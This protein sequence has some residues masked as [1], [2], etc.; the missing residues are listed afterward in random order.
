[1]RGLGKPR[2]ASQG[3]PRGTL[4]RVLLVEDSEN[5]AILLLRELRRGGYEPLCERVSTPEEMERALREAEERGE[6]WEV[7]VSDY[8]LPR[9][10]A[11]DALALLRRLGYVT[12]FILVSSKVGE[13]AAVAMMRAGAQDYVSKENLARL[14]PAIER[15]LREAADRRERAKAEEALR[16]SEDRFRRL[17]E[18]AADA[19]LVYDLEGNFVDVN[20]RACE[21]LGY[22]REE[23][24]GMSMG[25]VEAGEASGELGRLWEETSA[26]GPRT[27][28]TLHRRKDGTTFPV[29]VRVGVFELGGRPLVLALARDVT[30][31]KE[32]EKR[33]WEAETR[34]RTLVERIPAITYIQSPEGKKQMEYV[35]PQLEDVL[36]YS[37]E[38]E[39]IDDEFLLRTVHPE[40][41]DRFASEDRR[42]D[43]TGEPFRVE[44]RQLAS[45]G[46]EVW[47]R[48]EAVLVRDDEGRP[49]YWL[50]VQY[51]ITDRKRI[52]EDSRASEERY[53]AFIE[54][55]T[56]GIWRFEFEEEIPTDL[57][58]DEQISRIYR[59]GY[60]AECNDAMARMYGYER[61]EELAG[62]RLSDLLPPS[63]PENV[64]Y[65]RDA[66]RSGYRLTDAESSETD[67]E[68]NVKHFLNNLT[69]MI[70]EGR[71]VR[72]WG[73]Q[74]DV[75][76]RKK[77][78]MDLKESE[79]RFRAAF[80]QAAVGIVQ[81]ALDGAWIRFNDKFCDILGYT[82]E[83][84]AKISPLDL[85]T[86][87][88]FETDFERGVAMLSGEL[89]DYTEEKLVV[90]KDGVRVWINLTVSLVHDASDEPRYFIAV[91][92]DITKR[93]EAEE[94]LR[95]S[96]ERFRL[97]AEE[98][99]EGIAL[100]E[101][102]KIFDV[103]RSLA[104][105]F[106][107]EPEEVIG[108][109]ATE[110]VAPGSREEVARRIATGNTE[111]YESFGLKKDGTI[112]PIEVRP[113]RIPYFDRHVR[114][115]SII[116]LTERR[117]AEEQSRFLADLGQAL[118]LLTDPDE[119]V[120]TTAR[121]LGEHL[122]ADRCAYAEVEEDEDHFQLTGDYT[123]AGTPGLVGRFATSAFGA[124]ALRLMRENRPFVVEDAEA[125]ERVSAADLEAY[126]QMQIRALVGVPLHKEGRFVAGMAVHQETPRRWSREEVELVTRVA[127]RSWES[128]ERARAEEALRESEERFRALVQNSSDITAVLDA[129]GTILYESPA[130]ERVLGFGPDERTGANAFDLMDPE[131]AGPVSAAFAGLLGTPGAHRS[132]EYRMQDKAGD[133]HHF[134]AVGANLLEDPVIRG[135]VVNARDVTGRKRA[136]EALGESHA[137]LRSVI[138]GTDDA[139]FVKDLEGRYLMANSST[140]AVIGRP[141]EE[142]I[143]KNDAELFPPEVARRL[144]EA[145]RRVT[146]SG[147]TV[148]LEE[149]LP[150][151]HG[152]RTFLSTKAAYR[153]HRGEVVGIIGVATEITERKRAEE[154]LRRSEGLYRTVVEQ[155]A[156][157]IFIVDVETKLIL[158]ANT[159]L[160]RS[161]GYSAE[162]LKQMTIYDIVAH[163]R[164][165]IERNVER[166]LAEGLRFL[167]ERRYRRKD[168]D[169]VYVEASAS[170]IPYGN[171][172]AMCVVAHDVTERKRA[173]EALRASEERY[174]AVIEQSA[175]GLYL[176]DG[177]TKR[178]LETNPALQNS[179]GYTADELRGM[180]L[181]EIVAHD[182]ADVEANVERTLREGKRFIRERRYRRKD[183]S[184][185]EVEVAASAITYGG[186][187]VICAVIR[188]ITERREAERKLRE[189]REAERNRIARDLHD[190]IL[191]DIVYALQ[192]IQIVQITTPDG[193]D[194]ALEDAAEA[195]RRSVEGLRASIF[196][197][198][199]GSL[200]RSFVASVRALVDLN[201]RMARRRYAIEMSFEEG[202]PAEIS[203]RA[204]RQLTRI[205]QEAL[206]NVR[207][208]ANPRR[209]EVRLWREGESA[210]M[211]VADD[212][213]GFDPDAPVAGVGQQ[214]MRQRAVELGG[215]LEVESAPERGTRVRVR[216]PVSRLLHVWEDAPSETDGV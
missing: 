80:D 88:D 168:G 51:D 154:A 125:D 9:F 84:L 203:E 24:L 76:A 95:H 17:V 25:D 215:D 34:F 15:E 91:A 200:S 216:V 112:F 139:I 131:D 198:R 44:Y 107:Y 12:P 26:A 160:Q 71:L 136:E 1:L 144:M 40:D 66:I 193:G 183:G 130:V 98:V 21:A 152:T 74:R 75:T 36:G 111:A 14:C 201:R 110:V 38:K 158:E 178:I 102:G 181:H 49:L 213:H 210:C 161:L 101:N 162:E 173:E 108:M 103:N 67:R 33:L 141:A 135:M 83:E 8:Y 202:F 50:G 195:L 211:E 176:V 64:E 127:V 69:G 94:E 129:N 39:V 6:G 208:H 189:V 214:S 140:A 32:A 146:E 204:G 4:L 55:S 48:D 148:R 163:D 191:Q 113:R 99:V 28:E 122:G 45:D 59:C 172:E 19:M 169:F 153:D 123:R 2:G 90:G 134:E 79:E 63:V 196:E 104:E 155:A 68:G 70:E 30:E 114:V 185:V 65:L 109:D 128:I 87:Q 72:V 13:E 56:E 145:D 52:E 164:E 199:M 133:W 22:T 11:P 3:E 7:V 166:I 159:A 121:L 119:I 41:R 57:P 29:E 157:N 23:L 18:Q 177:G 92:E 105:M 132:V 27:L 142:L 96:E 37:P 186:K 77:A 187:R 212:G 16:E 147:E 62:T 138:E 35:S 97:L 209:V 106:G 150:A 43:Q 60:L 194:A 143:G 5:D 46:R 156:E 167:G 205:L 115:T 170:A 118:Q 192:E 126:R 151:G 117:R 149:E 179:L 73:T 89:R 86:P 85:V 165:S 184:V 47:F 188:D 120:A 42:T 58:E 78:E 197:L 61:A 53:R 81:V 10:R 175:E 190:D 82:R 31:R 124:E 100:N 20:R 180:E 93:R 54:Q 206:A 207:R 137:L 171:G 174:R 182:R 116:D